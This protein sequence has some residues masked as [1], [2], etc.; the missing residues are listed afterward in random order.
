MSQLKMK[1]VSRTRSLLLITEPF[2]MTYWK[3]KLN[4]PL[5]KL[6][7][8]IKNGWIHIFPNSKFEAVILPLELRSNKSNQRH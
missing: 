6:Q 4:S 7:M 5:N 3:A 1:I 8:L 2:E